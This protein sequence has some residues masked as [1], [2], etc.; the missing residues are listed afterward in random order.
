MTLKISDK[1]T[2][3]LADF[4]EEPDRRITDQKDLVKMWSMGGDSSLFSE[5]F[6]TIA[7]LERSKRR[8]VLGLC[9]AFLPGFIVFKL[10]EREVLKRLRA[11][12]EEDKI[13]LYKTGSPMAHDI[14]YKRVKASLEDNQSQTKMRITKKLIHD[15]VAGMNDD[16]LP[17]KDLKKIREWL[18]FMRGG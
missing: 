18:D 2:E 1:I 13:D 7:A 11:M 10:P 3:A 4:G 6:R 15:A 16:D 9:D 5:T 12:S 8:Y 14:L 17:E